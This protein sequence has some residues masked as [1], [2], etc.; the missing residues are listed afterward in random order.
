M[1]QGPLPAVRL[2]PSAGGIRLFRPPARF[3]GP[4]R[5]QLFRLIR[6]FRLW[7]SIGPRRVSCARR[8]GSVEQ[9]YQLLDGERLSHDG[10]TPVRRWDRHPVAVAGGKYERHLQVRQHPGDIDAR[11]VAQDQIENGGVRYEARE[12]MQG[13][14]N[15]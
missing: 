5:I 6:L 9:R 14:S 15:G 11:P 7:V 12:G 2:F 10:D 8:H 13:A 1:I 4:D 3:P